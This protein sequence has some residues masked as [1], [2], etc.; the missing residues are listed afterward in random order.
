MLNDT[1]IFSGKPA[2]GETAAQNENVNSQN[3]NVKSQNE[4]AKIAKGATLAS[5]GA[6]FVAGGV[7]DVAASYATAAMAAET[8]ETV[9]IAAEQ[10]QEP[11][12]EV[13]DAAAQLDDVA[14]QEPLQE[15]EPHHA[16]LR[17]QEVHVHNHVHVHND[18]VTAEAANAAHAQQ[19]AQTAPTPEPQVIPASGEVSPSVVENFE[20]D[21]VRIVE[22][23][24][25]EDHVAVVYDV[26]GD[27]EPD[28]AIVDMDD[29]LEISDADM[30]IGANGQ[31]ATVGQIA[32]ADMQVE[33]ESPDTDSPY[34]DLYLAENPD[35]APDM[36][37]YMNDGI[38]EA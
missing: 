28:V 17:P 34:D 29:N 12:D 35:V 7:A 8:V 19:V 2:N 27:S 10:E 13:A 26:D 4:K 5:A 18:S 30:V 24:M 21:G 20:L 37:D 33:Q 32:E 1:T 11:Q 16:S 14:N 36:P 15:T 38:V 3:E 23:G 22:A 31:M 6:G 9:D 25:V